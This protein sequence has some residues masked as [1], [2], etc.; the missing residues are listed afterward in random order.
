MNSPFNSFDL[1]ESDISSNQHCEEQQRPV[2]LAAAASS[3]NH[4]RQTY[5]TFASSSPNPIQQMMMSDGEGEDEEEEGEASRS[6]FLFTFHNKVQN[7]TE[8]LKKHTSKKEEKKNRIKGAVD[9]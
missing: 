2:R 4:E 3:G 5:L 9:S 6:N 7:C 8:L 1:S